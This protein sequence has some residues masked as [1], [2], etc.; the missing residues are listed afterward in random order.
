MAGVDS[1]RSELDAR[2]AELA[3]SAAE[4]GRKARKAAKKARK[5]AGRKHRDFE[6]AALATAAT[7]KRTVGAE[8]EP[9]RRWP[10]V[11]AALALGTAVFVFLRRK[12]DDDWTPAPASDGPVPSYREDPVPSSD[13]LRRQDRLHRQHDRRLRPERVGHGRPRRP[14]RRGRRSDGHR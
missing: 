4:S 13:E 8:P 12:Q 2:R 11:F 3:A 10:W 9:R 1:A 5:N 7:V 14:V 6:K